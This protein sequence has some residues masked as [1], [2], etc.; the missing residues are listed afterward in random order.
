MS[1]SAS[2]ASPAQSRSPRTLSP[3]WRWTAV[4]VLLTTAVVVWFSLDMPGKDL[5]AHGPSAHEEVTEEPPAIDEPKTIVTV[6]PAKLAEAEIQT[7]TVVRDMIQSVATV[8]GRVGYDAAR[9]LEVTTPLDCV[10]E[11]V[12][13]QPGQHVSQGDRLA[14]LS[15]PD[16]GLARDQVGRAKDDL[17][18]VQ[19]EYEYADDILKNLQNLLALLDQSPDPA[20]VAKQFARKRLGEHREHLLAAYSRMVFARKALGETDSLESSG[21]I[22]GRLMQQ[23]RSEAEVAGAGFESERETSLFECLQTRDKA[24]ATVAQ[25]ERQLRITEGRVKTM[26]G[27]LAVA[28]PMTAMD[29]LSRLVVVAAQDGRIEDR[30]VV[31]HQRLAAGDHLVTIADTNVLWVSANIH[32]REWQA[33]TLKAGEEVKVRFPALGEQEF[34]ANVRFLGAEVL[35]ETRSLPLVAEIA[36]SEGLLKPGMFAWIDLPIEAPRQAVIVSP[37]A[38]MRHENQAFVFLDE[39]QGTYRRIDVEVGEET[40]ERVEIISGLKGGERVAVSSTFI[41]KSELLLE[42]EE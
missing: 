26:L 16:I 8:S 13:V 36:N 5:F 29:D 14:I 34:T 24:A 39:G 31:K 17:A 30:A 6:S 2:V 28:E 32:E 33:T 22:S 20:E 19:R 11:E 21:A 18:L 9:R 25:A 7:E 38:L 1:R 15:S 41:L 10:V 3:V 42:Q 35:A 40:S 4:G 27:S 12:F 37:G 23:R